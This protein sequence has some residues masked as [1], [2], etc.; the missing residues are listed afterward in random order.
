MPKNKIADLRNHMFAQLE[1]LGDE[2]LKKEELEKE[3]RRAKAMSDIGK[4]IVESA[5]TELLHAKLTR[6][7][8]REA[9][10][11]LGLEEPEEE[12]KKLQRPPAV[13]GNKTHG[14]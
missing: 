14:Q 13:Y 8:E 9:E 5:K 7:N 11:F 1:R 4:V 12:K 10:R 6:K 3:I 2:T